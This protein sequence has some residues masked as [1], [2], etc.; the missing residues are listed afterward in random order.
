MLQVVVVGLH[1]TKVEAV[2]TVKQLIEEA[3]RQRSVGS[4]AANADSSRSHSIMQFAL[5]RPTADGEGKLIG[6]LSFI[7]LAGG[8]SWE[9]QH[10]TQLNIGV[11][12]AVWFLALQAIGSPAYGCSCL[13]WPCHPF[14][15]PHC[16]QRAWR[17][18]I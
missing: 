5:K 14:S 6:K 8:L 15:C 17:R 11:P 16:R 4:T 10:R 13:T 18:H 12:H 1:E 9:R 7:D 2:D 3:N